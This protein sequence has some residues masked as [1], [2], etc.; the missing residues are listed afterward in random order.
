MVNAEKWIENIEKELKIAEDNGDISGRFNEL[1]KG[2]II[3]YKRLEEY[4]LELKQSQNELSELYNQYFDLFDEAPV[5]YFS[6]DMERVVRNVNSKGVELLQLTKKQILG[7]NFI[8]FISPKYRNRFYTKLALAMDTQKKRVLELQ[9]IRDTPFY[10][11]MEIMPLPFAAN[12]K[13]RIIVIDITERKESEDKIKR[14]LGNIVESYVEYDNEWRYVDMNSKFEET[15]GLKRNEIIDRVVWEVL[16]QTVGSLQ[17]REFHKAKKENIPVNFESKSLVSGDWFEVHAFP[18]PEG[19]SVYLHNITDRKE[20]EE[21]LHESEE[22]YRLM[23][24]TAQEGIVISK[25]DGPYIFVNQKMADMLGYTQEEIDGRSSTDFMCSED[26][27]KQVMQAREDIGQDNISGEF[28][29]CCKD[30]TVL[31]TSYNASPFY[32]G[33]GNHIGNL[34][35]H[36]DI[37]KRKEA[38]VDLKKSEQRFSSLIIATSEVLY[39]M[40]P[41]WSVMLQLNSQG[42]LTNTEKPNPNWLQEYIPPE[43]QQLVTS[44]INEAIRTKSVFEL[45][46]RVWQ[47][48][49]SVGWTFS[50][51]VPILDDKCEII[52]W[53]GAASDITEG[54][55]AEEQLK[56]QLKN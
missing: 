43:D 11:H 44:A 25:P 6:L 16:P 54:K 34:A 55:K 39:Q 48:D 32:D 42:F 1:I 14:I 41:D 27:R 33:E 19:L 49:G 22:K 17:Y 20:A 46:H 9:L 53:F 7:H 23:V 29:F 40:S 45:E 50:R 18:H 21:A 10:V 56:K 31:W 38:E 36:T 3:R 15:F 26:Q 35:L 47:E 37:T 13:F 24:E 30:G 12:D 5:G 52:E 4:N 2:L 8:D 51:A 28:K